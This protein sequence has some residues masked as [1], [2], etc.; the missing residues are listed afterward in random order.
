M[1]VELTTVIGQFSI[2]NG[3]WHN[4]APNQVAVREPKSADRPGPERPSN[5]N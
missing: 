5:G 1:T 4:D 3:R 2:V